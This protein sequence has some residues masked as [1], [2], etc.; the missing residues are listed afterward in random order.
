MKD[1]KIVDLLVSGMV[2]L[3]FMG[4][5][6]GGRELVWI[7][8]IGVSVFGLSYY[9]FFVKEVFKSRVWLQIDGSSKTKKLTQGLRVILGMK[10]D[11]DVFKFSMW[12]LDFRAKLERSGAD[13]Y[14]DKGDGPVY[15]DKLEERARRYNEDE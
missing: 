5:F 3:V 4:I 13:F 11:V 10:N 7:I 6:S 12:E 1:V 9:L 2:G 15:L 8:L 14:Y